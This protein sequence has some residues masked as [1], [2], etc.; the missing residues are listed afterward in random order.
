[1]LEILNIEKAKQIWFFSIVATIV[2]KGLAALSL[3]EDNFL[4]NAYPIC[5]GIIELYVQL[6]LLVN[7]PEAIKAYNEFAKFDLD[8]SCISQTYSDE[9]NS[10]FHNRLNQNS[11]SKID[12][13]HFGWVD[14]ISD[15]HSI[16]KNTPYSVN[17]IVEYLR[18]IYSEKENG[19]FLSNLKV[20]F[21]M[22]HGYTHGSIG[23]SL[24]PL[25]HYFEISI[26]LYSTLS[27]TYLIICEELQ[28]DIGING[29]DVVSEL[30]QAYALLEKQ[31][32]NRSTENFNY[33][34]K[35]QFRI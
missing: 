24:Y 22:C 10:L 8:K 3:L 2:N 21:T 23:N 17:G 12:Y 31:Y 33:Y 9:F 32:G 34:Y 30:N 18:S 35:N 29:I 13:L 15:Y 7:K 5:R 1:M 16:V 4:D 20:L 25:L 19:T 27:H 26:M 11:K 14:C 6:L 28:Q